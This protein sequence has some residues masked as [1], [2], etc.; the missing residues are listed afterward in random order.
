EQGGSLAARLLKDRISA[1]PILKRN[2]IAAYLIETAVPADEY[3]PGAATPACIARDQTGCVMA[4][5]S[6]GR[7]EFG[8]AQR[9][10]NR[11]LVWNEEG[12][13]TGLAGR[14]PLCVNPLLGIPSRA[15]APARLNLGA[16]NAAGL[17]W[18]AR[19]GF[20][21]RQ[22]D[23]QCVDGILRVGRPRSA[24]LRPA[25]GWA[26]RLRARGYNLF[27]GDLEADARRRTARFLA[28]RAKSGAHGNLDR[29]NPPR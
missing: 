5:I 19:P 16:V 9:I 21:A 2:M 17:E 10:F 7:G 4:W 8:R 23:A 28:P 15:D 29:P 27:Y 14:E 20:M 25:G 22:V 3:G 13:L 18:G 6:V 26:E 24:S 12:R 11:A 1:N